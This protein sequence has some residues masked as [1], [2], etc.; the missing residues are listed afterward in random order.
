[1]VG[2]VNRGFYLICKNFHISEYQSEALHQHYIRS[3]RIPIKMSRGGL[4]ERKIV[5]REKLS[6]LDCYLKLLSEKYN[7]RPPLLILTVYEE[8][9]M[10]NLSKFKVCWFANY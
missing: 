10:T 9:K 5:L 3:Y 6:T 1:M 7:F 8:R 4:A 2:S